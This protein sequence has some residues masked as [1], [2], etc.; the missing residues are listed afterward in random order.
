LV[1]QYILSCLKCRF[2]KQYL[3]RQ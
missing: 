2:T 1:E 3:L